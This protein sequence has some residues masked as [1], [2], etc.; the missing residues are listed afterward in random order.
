MLPCNQKAKK[1]KNNIAST[2]K[3]TNT[4]CTTNFSSS[5][6]SAPRDGCAQACCFFREQPPA[7]PSSV[8]GRRPDLQSQRS[9]HNAKHAI[10]FGELP[11]KQQH[12]QVDAEV[13]PGMACPIVLLSFG[14]NDQHRLH[15]YWARDRN[16]RPETG[17]TKSEVET[18]R[19]ACNNF[20][21]TTNETITSKDHKLY[22]ESKDWRTRAVG[23]LTG[24][25]SKLSSAKEP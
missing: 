15:V 16:Y 23:A 11:M 22:S 5:R 25:Y 3:T 14:S 1:Q 6:G 9:R 4:N 17:T 19:Q 12:S 20:W 10:T 18:Q 24:R 7:S 21:R 13:H 2:N 8:S